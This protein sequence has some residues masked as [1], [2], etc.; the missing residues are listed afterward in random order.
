V[1]QHSRVAYVLHHTGAFLSFLSVLRGLQDAYAEWK[2]QRF[3]KKHGCKTR[4]VYE[5]F[6]DNGYNP[7]AYF[8]RDMYPGYAYLIAYEPWAH[9]SWNG[10]ADVM[11]SIAT[12]LEWCY[13]NCEA[14]FRG[15]WHRV[16]ENPVT[17]AFEDNG[18]AGRDVFFLAFKSEKDVLMFNLRWL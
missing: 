15:D 2:E 17:G 13:S 12:I 10:Y 18:I 14:K 1:L 5:R 9:K 8:V 11:D 6:F 7:R 16:I 3:L 4:R